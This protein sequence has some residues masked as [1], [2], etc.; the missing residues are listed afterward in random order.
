MKILILGCGK[1]LA[2]HI[3]AL[4]T[5]GPKKFRLVGLCDINYKVIKTLKKKYNVP[6]FVDLKLA[7]ENTKPDIVTILLPSGLHANYIKR[8]LKMGKNVIVEKPMCLT[9]K[10]AKDIVKVSN[11]MKK[12]VFVVM[13]NKFNLPVLKLLKDLKVNKLGRIFHGS[14]IVRWRR[15]KKYYNQSAWRGTW[16]YDGGVISNQASHHLD[17]LKTIMGDPISVFAKNFNHL[18]NIEAEDT[19][20]VIFKFKNNKSAILEATT[21]VR[22]KNLE[23]SISI[24]GSKGSVKI[25]GFALNQVSYYN[26]E[27]NKNIIGEKYNQIDFNLG[28]KK[29][30]NHVFYCLKNNLISEFNAFESMKTVKL[31]NAI[32]KSAES[33]KEVYLKGNINSKKL[34]K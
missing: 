32:Y 18:A 14:V 24:L 10:D 22:P 1:I 23:G 27:K 17:L 33:Q 4:Y 9:M 6:T 3:D 15:D 29:F 8:I 21:A 13:Q 11:K 25:G 20:L 31:I 16:R 2:K 34:G 19:S 7:I 28:H 12:K 26:I 5:L 30:Y